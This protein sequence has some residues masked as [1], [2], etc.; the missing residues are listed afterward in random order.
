MRAFEIAMFTIIALMTLH[1]YQDVMNPAVKYNTGAIGNTT[2]TAYGNIPNIV[3]TNV[4]APSD[5]S[6]ILAAL[7]TAYGLFSFMLSFMWI[8]F[9]AVFLVPFILIEVG[10]PANFV[11]IITTGIW[12]VYGAA[13]MQIWT[14]RNI[15]LSE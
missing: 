6:P 7:E 15:A 8:L 11:A 4:L 14:G 1:Y 5:Q 12:I 13:A 10:L 9:K 2:Q 3:Y